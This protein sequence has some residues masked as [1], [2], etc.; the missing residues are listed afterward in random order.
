MLFWIAGSPEPAGKLT[1]CVV[2]SGM[3]WSCPATPDAGRCITLQMVHGRPMPDNQRRTRALH[4]VSKSRWLAM[5]LGLMFG[6]A[7][8]E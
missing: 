1:G 3:N 5:R 2:E 7:A 8:N 6:S 4:S